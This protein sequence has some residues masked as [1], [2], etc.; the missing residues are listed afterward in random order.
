MSEIEN[1]LC[2][3]TIKNL[4]LVFNI[5]RQPWCDR[6]I[7]KKFNDGVYICSCSV[8]SE[9][10]TCKIKVHLFIT[11]TSKDC[12]NQNFVGAMLII[13]QAHLFVFWSIF[14]EKQR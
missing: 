12:I 1:P 13:Q 10:Y 11:F 9:E 3:R 5:E 2:L 8:R 6:S 7:L 14:P 4:N